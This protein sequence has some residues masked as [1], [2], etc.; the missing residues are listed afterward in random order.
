M[1]GREYRD[2]AFRFGFNNKERDDE[3]NGNGNIYNYGMRIYNSS[4]GKFLSVDPIS[5]KYP[6]LS[7]YQFGSNMPICAIDL[8][9]LEA[10]ISI[11]GSSVVDPSSVN[12]FRAASAYD[13]KMQSVKSDPHSVSKASTFVKLLK[14]KTG[15]E[16][17]IGRIAIFSHASSEAMYFTDGYSRGGTASAFIKGGGIGDR[18]SI[19]DQANFNSIALGMQDGSIK[20]ESN[21][22]VIFA[23]CNTASDWGPNSTHPDQKGEAITSYAESFTAQ[24]HIS[25]IGSAGDMNVIVNADKSVS[26]KSDYGFYKYDYDPKTQNVVSTFLG[27][28]LNPADYKMPIKPSQESTATQS[29]NSSSDSSGQKSSSDTSTSPH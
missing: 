17:S 29:G 9:G 24:L 11:Y 4:L 5:M 7:T 6:Q 10:N 20:F 3:V 21:A 14:E 13:A 26:L 28:T 18:K 22:L 19:P 12:A 27:K 23:G 15:Q 1:P 25:S 16:G 8:D 2:T